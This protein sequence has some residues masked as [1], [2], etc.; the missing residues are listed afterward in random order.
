[1]PTL[2]LT[3]LLL[4][5]VALAV[6]A[7]SE[8]LYRWTTDEGSVAFSDDLKRVPERYRA[9]AKAIETRRLPGY[10]RYTPTDAQAGA[11]HAERLAARLERLREVNAPEPTRVTLPLGVAQAGGAE[12]VLRLNDRTTVRVPTAR[13]GDGEGPVVV[14]EVRVRRPGSIVTVHNT[15]VRRGDDI[16]LVVR[17]RQAQHNVNDFVDERDYLD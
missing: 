17:P 5:A 4:L 7:S 14:D 1:M 2:K 8:T 16:L 6:P 12:T 10:A 11:A 9:Q 13:P 15:V 3:V